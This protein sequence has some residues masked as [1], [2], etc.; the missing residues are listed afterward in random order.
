M[1]AVAAAR[2]PRRIARLGGMVLLVAGI[3]LLAVVVFPQLVGA[4]GSYVVLS[5]SMHPTIHAGDVV[6]SKHVEP[7]A[8]EEGDILVFHRESASNSDRTTHRVVDVVHR[9]DGLYFRTKGDA[10]ENPDVGLVSADDVIGRV[11][12]HVPYIGHLLL[13]A[14]TRAGLLSLVVLPCLLI[15]I[16]EAYSLVGATRA[17]SEDEDETGGDKDETDGKDTR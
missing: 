2:K 10:N 8:I 1:M 12:F 3:L 7:S 6:V 14:R 4:S 13:F 5:G 17:K 9:D 16:S 11:W 15:V